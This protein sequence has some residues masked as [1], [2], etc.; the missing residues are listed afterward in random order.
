MG[1]ALAATLMSCQAL[2]DFQQ[3]TVYVQE[4][5]SKQCLLANGKPTP[6]SWS[7]VNSVGSFS[8]MP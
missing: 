1:V 5:G 7:S 4:S 3:A 8:P 6:Y 2:A